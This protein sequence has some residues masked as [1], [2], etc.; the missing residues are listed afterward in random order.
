M[1]VLW[2]IINNRVFDK[3]L[4][5]TDY[6]ALFYYIVFCVLVVL[7]NSELREIFSE[8][9][10]QKRIAKWSVFLCFIFISISTWKYMKNR[11]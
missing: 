8:N 4:P 10:S 6:K 9:Y 2:I 7:F 11:K 3:S 1:V 5:N